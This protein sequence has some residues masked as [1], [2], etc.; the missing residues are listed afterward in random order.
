MSEGLPGASRVIDVAEDR[1]D[2]GSEVEFGVKG[3][4]EVDVGN[5][6]VAKRTFPPAAMET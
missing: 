5:V 1:S 2:V 6:A 3:K 4:I